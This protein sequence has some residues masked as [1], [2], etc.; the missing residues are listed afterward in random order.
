MRCRGGGSGGECEGGGVGD[1]A[2]GFGKVVILY[3]GQQH[4]QQYI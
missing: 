1:D 3:R 4:Q 2:N